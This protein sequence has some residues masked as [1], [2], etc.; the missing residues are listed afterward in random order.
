MCIL[1]TG[2]KWRPQGGT[3]NKNG[4]LFGYIDSLHLWLP[5][6]LL[7][8][9]F[10][11]LYKVRIVRRFLTLWCW[12][13]IPEAIRCLATRILPNLKV[14]IYGLRVVGLHWNLTGTSA[15]GLP[16]C[17]L[18]FRA[19]WSFDTQSRSFATSQDLVVRCLNIYWIEA[20]MG[21]TGVTKLPP[22]YS[23]KWLPLT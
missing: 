12:V 21:F 13:S 1:V 19:K 15:A 20:L 7:R 23:V 9:Q 10:R 6:G 22:T 16:R 2:L 8:I 5:V 4:P 14:T 3:Q 11:P 18:F 17:L